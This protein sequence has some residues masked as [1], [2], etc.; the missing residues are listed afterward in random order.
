M[1]EKSVGDLPR[2]L[3]ELYQKGTIALQRQ[4]FDYA[5]AIL[6]QVLQREPSFLEAR[7]A[8]RASQLR[9]SGGTTSFFKRV[10][11]GAGASPLIAKAQMAKSR[12]PLEAMQIAEQILEG[13][14]NSSAGHKILAEAAMAAD[15][16]KTACFAYELL[17][18]NNSRD[19]DLSMAYGEALSAA[20]QIAKAEEHYQELVQ[21]H[22]RKSEIAMALKNLAARK[23]LKEGGYDAL[24]DG[25]GSYRDI[26]KDKTES[27]RLEQ[28]NRVVK[29]EDVATQLIRE[30]E[31][32]LRQEPK[33]LKLMRDIAEL[34]AQKKDFD[35]SSN[36]TSASAPPTSATIRPSK[37]PS[38][39]P[40]S[41]ASIIG[42]T[43]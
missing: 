1:A 22:P 26:L 40:L 35:K 21:A 11:G 3:R 42:W 37:R 38:R 31:V 28:E 2:D 8:L 18:R 27:V 39:R 4:N 16:P 12:N 29:A 36:T 9:K 14:P 19:Y 7:Q 32:R 13:D 24:A 17:L 10:L 25:T 15:L 30:R 20:G 33:N 34:H 41:S 6:Q 43:N 5:I 23:T